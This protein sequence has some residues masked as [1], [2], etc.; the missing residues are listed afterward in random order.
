MSERE[1]PGPVSQLE[2]ARLSIVHLKLEGS[3]DLWRAV[4]SALRVSARSLDVAR[5]GLWL[6]SDDRTALHEVAKHDERS[7]AL[8]TDIDRKWT[9]SLAGWP[10]YLA[11]ITSRRVIAAGDARTDP[12]TAELRDG[13]LDALGIAALLDAPVFVGGTVW[14]VVCHEHVGAARPWS[15][16]EID[17]AV[18]VADMLSALLEQSS[19]IEAQ[20]LLLVEEQAAAGARHAEAL[21]RTVAAIGHDFNTVLQSVTTL[22]EGARREG[23]PAARDRALAEIVDASRQGSRIVAQLR[24]VGRPAPAEVGGADLSLV[25]EG[26][27]RRLEALLAPDH[28][29]ATVLDPDALVAASR[30]DLE[31]ILMNLAVNAREAM[32][33]GGTVHVAV[34]AAG[35][36]V[37]L[38]VRDQGVG[39]PAAVRD[40]VFE[41]YFTTKIERSSGLGLFAVQA[42]ATQ[43]GG[44][45]DLTSVEGQGTEVAITWPRIG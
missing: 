10:A 27:R 7:G 26:L 30:P 16:R 8:A 43:T 6:L 38:A 41:P 12:R 2:A 42:I 9:L 34:R 37:V 19:R 18:S 21:V 11:A 32:P 4:E 5:V 29:L 39:I 24:D 20:R 25:V 1:Q 15:Q 17:F 33:A 31:R 28:D 22:A 40:R 35:Q 3:E 13:Y 14:G 44:T 36:T 45:I 23:D